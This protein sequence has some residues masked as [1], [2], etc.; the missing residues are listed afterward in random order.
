MNKKL[1][2]IFLAFVL[3]LSAV[4]AASAETLQIEERDV[5]FFSSSVSEPDGE[6]PLYFV[7]GV[8]DLPYLELEDAMEVLYEVNFY[9]APESYN[10]VMD[11]DGPIVTVT[12]ENE[13]KME[14][15]FEKDR[16]TF[17]DYNAF[18]TTGDDSILLDI[19]YMP[20]YNEEG[21]V[22]L[23]ERDKRASYDRYG[24]MVTIDLAA[25]SI[26][27]IL[28]DDLYLIPLQTV[29]DLLLSPSVKINLLYNG[30]LLVLASGGFMI[31][32]ET[33][34]LSELAELYY[35]AEPRELSPELA[36]FSYNELCLALDTLYGLK[37]PHEITTFAQTFWE[38]GFDE[39]LSSVSPLDHDLALHQFINYYLDD[40]HS[41]Y[42][43]PSPY[44]GLESMEKHDLDYGTATA[45]MDEHMERYWEARAAFYPDG[46]PGYEEIGNTAYV[47]FDAFTFAFEPED[48]YAYG[49]D[50]EPLPDTIGLIIY[51]HSQITRPDSPIENVVLDLSNNTGGVADTAVFVISWMLGDASISLKDTNSGAMSNAVYRADVNLDRVFDENDTVLDKNLYCLISPVSFSCG[52]LVPAALKAS[53]KVT[54]LGTTSGGGSCIVQPMSDALGNLFNLSGPKRL[55]LLK[56]GSFYDIDQGIDPDY[57]ID[58]ISHY[59]DREALTDYINSLF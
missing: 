58:K 37:G 19:L 34:D 20:G 30:E 14:L 16:I 35:S 47:T 52:N 45:R 40:Q 3:L 33:G 7:N 42:L 5:P 36:D 18:L 38:I 17:L 54:L 56:N 10:M 15:D 26:D 41:Y 50:G 11:Y 12:R 29:N 31:D 39:P 24:D 48:Y 43:L 49:L 53:Q 22:S 59:F 4:P 27:L 1:L 13:Y 32:E 21:E 9:D 55:S 44:A 2:S 46:V 28:Q 8:N 57:S 25:Y 51:A 23:F 6:F